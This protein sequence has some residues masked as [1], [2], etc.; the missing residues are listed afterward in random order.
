MIKKNYF[1]RFLKVLLI[2]VFALICFL[3][4]PLSAQAFSADSLYENKPAQSDDPLY[5]ADVEN[6]ICWVVADG[7]WHSCVY[8]NSNEFLS[9]TANIRQAMYDRESSHITYFAVDKK[10]DSTTQNLYNQISNHIYDDDGM[11]YGGDYLELMSSID[12]TSCRLELLSSSSTGDYNFYRLTV[13]IDNMTTKA[14]EDAIKGFLNNFNKTYILDNEKISSA[15]NDEKQYY[16]VKTIYNFVTKNTEYDF[17]VYYGKYDKT[18]E[19]HRYAHTAFGALF[20]NID[21][22]YNPDNFKHLAQMDFGMQVDSQGLYRIDAMNNGCSV[23]DGYSLV[24]YYLCKLNNIDCRIVKG[25]NVDGLKSDPHAWNMVRLKDYNDDG[26]AWYAVDATFAGQGSKKMS[27]AIVITDYSFFLRG[28]ENE[29]FSPENHQQVYEEYRSIN[30]STSDYQFEIKD[31]FTDKLYT[32]VTRRRVD[33]NSSGDSG[34]NSDNLENYMVIAP[35]GKYYKF[36]SENNNKLV[37]SKGFVYYSTGYYYSCEFYDFAKGIEY[38]CYD[39]F[40]VDAGTYRFDILTSDKNVIYGKDVTVLKLDLSDMNNYDKDL[41]KYPEHAN[42][43]GENIS[44]SAEIYDNSKRKL[45]A[46]EDYGLLCYAKGDANKTNIKPYNPGEYVVRITYSGNYTGYI[47]IPFTVYKAN[48]AQ[49]NPPAE[50]GV[51]YGVDIAKGYS[52][53]SIGNTSIYEGKDYKI[54]V[55][56]GKNNGDTGKIVITGLAGSEYVQEGTSTQWNYHIVAYDISSLYDDKYISNAKYP[57]TGKAIEPTNFTLSYIKGGTD[58]KI[59]LVRDKD[60]KI[61]SYSDNVSAGIGK[62]KIQFMGNYTGTAVMKFYIEYGQGSVTCADLTYNGK[63]QSPNPVVKVGDVV[64]KKGTDY[65]VSGSAT[66]PGVYSGK[67][68]GIGQFSHISGSFIY[69][70][71]PGTLTGVKT[72]TATNAINVSWTKQGNNCGYEVYVY[73]T[74]KKVWRFVGSTSGSSYKITAVYYNGSKTAVKANTQYKIRVRAYIKGTVN[75][76]S[77]TKVGPVKEITER[78]NPAALSGVKHSTA[79]NSITVSWTK[80]SGCYYQVYVYDTGKKTW[81]YIGYTSNNSYKITSVYVNGKSTAVKANTQYK[82]RVRAYVT[83]TYNGVKTT[84]YGAI[85]EFTE[86]TNPA[87]L[88]GVKSSAARNYINVSWTKQSGCYYQVYVYDAKKKTWKYIGS[89]SNGSYKITSVYV[90]GKKTSVKANTTYQIRVRAVYNGT[91]NGS[92]VTKYGAVKQISV[93]TKK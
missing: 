1:S 11:P 62:V 88:S 4:L 51:P 81:R 92:K 63:I 15:G 34:I 65:T 42:F 46:G 22:A 12:F 41:T 43:I 7:T 70:I 38:T 48:L 5:C 75:G 35:D 8:D 17:D 18:T 21:G 37:E 83:G 86:R 89:T 52:K 73:D 93:R 45:I 55:T 36:D 49:L 33:D 57:Y 32:V 56:G 74:G 90:N 29:S 40:I 80:Q 68:T 14:E 39:Q 71:T 2:S 54:T 10:T 72:S 79:Y 84:K 19:R 13:K 64:L 23:C 44:I 3:A 9:V 59:T 78:T 16:T 67:I 6:G 69:Y 47:E 50:K 61:V 20:G 91:L 87:T 60:Y 30:Q 58:E 28:S 76:T 26:Y 31:I 85:T 53:L 24:F 77:F 66:N 25:D 82:I 27:N